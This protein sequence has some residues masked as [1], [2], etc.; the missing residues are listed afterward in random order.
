MLGFEGKFRVLERGRDQLEE[1]RNEVS[2]LIKRN[3]RSSAE[4]PLSRTT[5]GTKGG[6]ELG[7]FVP[8]WVAGLASVLIML[9][10]H[11]YADFT[12]SGILDPVLTRIDALAG[13]RVP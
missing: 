3:S 13:E 4:E 1:L 8:L 9:I 2:R 10:V 5:R 7:T 12:M 11:G 6:K